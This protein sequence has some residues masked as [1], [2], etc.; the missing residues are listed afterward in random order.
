MTLVGAPRGLF[1]SA[2]ELSSGK[3]TPSGH[4][5]M[6]GVP[7]R[8]EWGYFADRENSFPPALLAALIERAGLP[9]VLGNRH[10]SGTVIIDELGAEHCRTKKPIVYTSADSVFQIAAHET[11]FGLE[12][13]A[14]A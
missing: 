9:G 4:W 3:D 13:R 10:A 14:T 12:R 5:E 2:A 1:G 6:A 7:V 11:Y 8:F